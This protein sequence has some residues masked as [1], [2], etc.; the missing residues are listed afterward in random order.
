[1]ID[2][3]VHHGIIGEESDDLHHAAA[4]RA[5]ERVNL[6]NLPDHLG[7]A[8]GIETG[9]LPG[10]ETFRPFG[11]EKLLVDQKPKNFPSKDLRQPRVVDPGD[12][13]F[14]LL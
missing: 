2:D 9:M 5:E 6:I 11:A 13:N 3:P 12:L 8:L 14:A 7:P 10:E 4:S 1:V